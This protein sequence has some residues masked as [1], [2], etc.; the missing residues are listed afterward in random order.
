VEFADHGWAADRI[1]DPQDPATR[2]SAVLDWAEPDRPGPGRLLAWYRDLI[3]L[4]RSEPQLRA[5]D[6]RA[7]RV[8]TGASWIAVQRGDL[9]VVANLGATETVVDLPP[10]GQV[11]LS[12][13]ETRLDGAGALRLPA[14]SVAVVRS[15]TRAG[16]R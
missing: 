16:H 5:D 4:R 7:V 15:G 3:A 13:G 11:V 9:H 1:P 6:L 10:P 14:E 2:R 12:W 8:R